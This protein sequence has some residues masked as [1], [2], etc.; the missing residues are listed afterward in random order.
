MKSTQ[1]HGMLLKFKGI[2]NCEFLFD[3]SY[4]SY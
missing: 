4:T 1:N 2:M 3:Y